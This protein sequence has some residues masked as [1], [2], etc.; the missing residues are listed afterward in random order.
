MLWAKLSELVCILVCFARCLL[1]VSSL[2][3][4]LKE[5][6]VAK[7]DSQKL[8]DLVMVKD[9]EISELKQSSGELQDSISTLRHEVQG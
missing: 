2:Q 6:Q 3:A 9:N 8:S 1:G 7:V 4:Q 5:L